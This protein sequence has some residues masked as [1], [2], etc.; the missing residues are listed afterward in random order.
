MYHF[1]TR[2]RYSEVDHTGHLTTTALVNLLQDCATFHSEDVGFGV[3][4]LME[5]HLG[6]FVT[7][8]QIA[9]EGEAPVLGDRVT[10]STWPKQFRGM[11]GYRYLTLARE[12]G[13]IYAKVFS[14]WVF[15]DLQRGGPAKI[16]PEMIEAY[17]TPE[18]MDGPWKGRKIPLR[19][20]LKEIYR[21]TVTKLHLDTNGHMN[22]AH[23]IDAAAA[24]LPEDFKI[25]MIATEYKK[26]AKEG[27]EICVCAAMDDE[28]AQAVLKSPEGEV[29]CII[30]FDGARK[31]MK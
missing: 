5:H 23:H 17:G 30:A 15:M 27:D 11:F 6:W 20:D 28:A 3:N 16:P 14:L 13:S 22:N 26:E 1:E 4:W 7:N 18:E 24:A 29:Y 31:G 12:D 10:V 9:Y 8:W 21:F 25:K 2:I 19:E